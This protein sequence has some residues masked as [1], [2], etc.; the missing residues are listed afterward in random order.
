MLSH[1]RPDGSTLIGMPQRWLVYLPRDPPPGTV[2]RGSPRWLL[3]TSTLGYVP[4]RLS[5][6]SCTGYATARV[7]ACDPVRDRVPHMIF[8][9]RC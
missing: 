1:D 7:L 6:V 2:C 4:R 9:T 8:A 3:R 5:V